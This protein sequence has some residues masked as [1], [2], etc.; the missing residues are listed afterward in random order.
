VSQ[1][2]LS[3]IRFV[4]DDQPGIVACQFSDALE[5][6]HTIIDKAPMFTRDPLDFSSAYPK[7]GAVRCEVLELSQD[8]TGRNLARITLER[9]DCV[10]STTFISEFN[11]HCEQRIVCD[12]TETHDGWIILAIARILVCS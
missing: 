7:P 11:P 5:R 12:A 4:A 1:L 2:K 6:L 10:E 8:E 3:I 9:P